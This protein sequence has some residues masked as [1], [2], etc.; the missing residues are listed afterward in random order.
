M[1]RK[2][3]GVLL[4]GLVGLLA[5]TRL[6]AGEDALKKE[7]AQLQLLTGSDPT[8]G[9]FKNVVNSKDPEH[10]KKLIA[11][12]LPLAKKKELTYN[13]ALVLGLLAAELKDMKSSEAFLRV[14]MT[15]AAQLQSFS[16]LKQSYGLAI[17]LNYEYRNYEACSRLCKE[18]LELNTDDGKEREVIATMFNKRRGE[19]EFREAEKGF[20]TAERLR[21]L[22]REIHVKSTA[23]LGKYDQALKMVDS[24]LKENNDWI[25]LQIKGWVLREA[26]KLDAAA[27]VLEDVI[28]QIGADDRFEATQRDKYISGIRQE[29]SNVYVDLKKIDRASEH[30]EILIKKQPEEPVFYND[31]GYIWADNDLKLPE[32]EKLIRK[33]LELDRQRRQKL[34]NFNAKEDRD[35]GAYLDSMGWVLYKQKKNEE[36]KEFLLKA[37]KDQTSQHIE[38]YDHLGD[39]HMALGERDAAIRAWRKGVELAGEGRRDQE[40]KTIVEKKLKDSSK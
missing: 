15:R 34:P 6:P 5:A 14:C 37:V 33:A 17:E 23:K 26:G 13:A 18:L 3:S 16:K 22:V 10:S 39:V 30:L 24:L 40:R 25:N 11:A 7:I 32:A 4:I 21:P 31:L 12:A 38:I 20:D 1:V 19:V 8:S 27:N 29:V 35:N 28:K 9:A 2:M 36:A